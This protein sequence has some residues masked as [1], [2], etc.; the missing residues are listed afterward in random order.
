V[1]RLKTGIPF[2]VVR[3]RQY[4]LDGEVDVHQVTGYSQ[5]NLYIN[6]LNKGDRVILVD[7]V[8][9]T[10]GTMIAVLNALKSMGVDVVDVLAIMEKG[11]GKEVVES[12]TGFMVKTLL[13][14]K[15]EDG[16]VI[17]EDEIS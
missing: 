2:V 11:K 10:G 6:G 17:I 12:E 7:D 13:K 15:V 5:G 1:W 9:S 4:G 8:V 3:K 14:V 16:K